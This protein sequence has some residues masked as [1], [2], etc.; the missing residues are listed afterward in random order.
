MTI[1]LRCFLGVA[2]L[3]GWGLA[4]AT[5]EQAE[6][7]QI[8]TDQA[9]QLK[10]YRRVSED[11]RKFEEAY[12]KCLE[13]IPK[14]DYT[15]KR[16]KDCVGED[17]SLVDNDI[18]FERKKVLGSA[19]RKIR[20]IMIEYCYKV[21]GLDTVISNGCDLIERDALDLLWAGLNFPSLLSYHSQKYLFEYGQVPSTVFTN[22]IY[23]FNEMYGPLDDLLAEIDNHKDLTMI[24]LKEFIENKTKAIVQLAI[25]RQDDPLPKITTQTI[26]IT[27]AV[28]D[29]NSFN[30][31]SLPRPIVQGSA[32]EVK[33]IGG[34][35]SR[36]EHL[37]SFRYYYP[38]VVEHK[39]GLQPTV[40]ATTFT[41]DHY[42]SL[43]FVASR[44]LDDSSQR[45]KK[46][47]NELKGNI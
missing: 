34:T 28:T 14:N 43:K 45:T 30:L 8:S 11:A 4:Q 46:A 7:I 42:G 19:D 38:G 12:T 37:N 10:N 47:S 3:A 16:I 44:K 5:P 35:G 24:Q 40:S 25:E 39:A 17:F 26:K 33:F 2:L 15:E 22:V 32:E 29:P 20:N 41:K 36:N 23:F 6:P 9:V 13:D 31:I 18:S 1:M 27:Q 21:A